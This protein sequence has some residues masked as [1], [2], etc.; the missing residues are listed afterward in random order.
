MA[1]ENNEHPALPLGSNVKGIIRLQ[2]FDAVG[3]RFLFEVISLSGRH[4]LPKGCY[5]YSVSKQDWNQHPKG[6]HYPGGSTLERKKI[7][8]R[9]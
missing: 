1:R 7:M 2:T 4:P 9:F 3:I 8:S 6:W 5:S